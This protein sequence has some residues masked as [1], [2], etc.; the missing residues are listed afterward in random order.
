MSQLGHTEVILFTLSGVGY[1]SHSNFWL[2]KHYD[3]YNQI[4]FLIKI[5][6]PMYFMW[7]MTEFKCKNIMSPV[8]F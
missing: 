5:C 8:N 1:W 7:T 6:F 3:E 2:F 4:Y